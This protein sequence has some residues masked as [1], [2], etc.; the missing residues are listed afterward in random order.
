MKKNI[1]NNRNFGLDLV[2]CIAILSVVILHFGTNYSLV[3]KK[4][5]FFTDTRWCEYIFCFEWLFNWQYYH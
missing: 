5:I 4:N 2:R 3:F 1:S